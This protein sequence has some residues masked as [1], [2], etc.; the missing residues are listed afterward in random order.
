M[1]KIFR[2]SNPSNALITPDRRGTLGPWEPDAGHFIVQLSVPPGE[3]SSR[4]SSL[5]AKIAGI[6]KAK[7]SRLVALGAEEVDGLASHVI[8]NKRTF[9]CPQGLAT[10]GLGLE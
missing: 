8:K 6:S 3:I 4:K 7:E 10:M 2:K 1:T 9:I 5:L